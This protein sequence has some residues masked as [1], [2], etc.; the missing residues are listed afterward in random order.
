M[1]GGACVAGLGSGMCVTGEGGCACLGGRRPLLGGGMHDW[2]HARPYTFGK[3]AVRILLECYTF[4]R[5][6]V[7]HI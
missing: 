1:A 5:K 2:K 6:K 4:T 3:Q 7:F